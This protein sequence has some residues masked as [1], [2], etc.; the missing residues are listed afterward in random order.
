MTHD[1]VVS[2]LPAQSFTKAERDGDLSAVWNAHFD[3]T[4]SVSAE[5]LDGPERECDYSAD[6]AHEWADASYRFAGAKTCIECGARGVDQL[7]DRGKS[8]RRQAWE[9]VIVSALI[10][11]TIFLA[12]FLTRV[13][14]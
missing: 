9:T 1:R 13:W 11:G 10:A 7:R 3:P 8:Y 12:E 4:A 6:G 14:F 2:V 5:A